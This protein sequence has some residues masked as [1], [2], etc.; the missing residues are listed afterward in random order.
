MSKCKFDYGLSGTQ[1]KDSLG[2]N[3]TEGIVAL[4]NSLSQKKAAILDTWYHLIMET[5]PLDTSMVLKRGKDRFAN[6]VE[7]TIS[8]EIKVLYEEL[9]Q[10]ME[11]DRLSVHWRRRSSLT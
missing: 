2:S 6:P 4:E 3:I 1:I 8:Q 9:L 11:S 5:Y 10:N 7:Y